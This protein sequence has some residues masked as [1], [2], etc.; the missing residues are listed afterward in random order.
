MFGAGLR[1]PPRWL[2]AGLLAVRETFGQVPW[3]GQETGHNLRDYCADPT[4][5]VFS[6]RSVR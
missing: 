2:A 3:L 1:T 4:A 5:T 6:S